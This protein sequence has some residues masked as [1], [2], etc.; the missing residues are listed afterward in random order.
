MAEET[1]SPKVVKTDAEW[2]AQP[3]PELY[4]MTGEAAPRDLGAALK[5]DRDDQQ[6]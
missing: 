5:L 6:T 3:S 1:R 2:H 4:H